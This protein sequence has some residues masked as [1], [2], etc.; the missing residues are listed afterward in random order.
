MGRP[1]YSIC[2]TNYNTVDVIER[3]LESIINRINFSDC[4][5]I[6]VDSK[7]TDGSLEILRRYE[8]KYPQFKVIVKKCLRG[9]GWQTAFENSKGEFIIIVACD[10]IYNDLWTKIIKY[11]MRNNLDFALSMWFCQIYPRG[12]LIKVGGWNNLQYLEDADLWARIA[13]YKRYYTY[14]VVCGENLKRE[15]AKNIIERFYR[16]Y[17]RIHDKL[18]VTRNIPIKYYLLGYWKAICRKWI[19]IHRVTRIIF[20]FSCL[21]PAVIVKSLRRSLHKYGDIATLREYN[22]VVDF[23]FTDKNKLVTGES[24]DTVESVKK[25]YEEGD[26][27]YL[28]GFYD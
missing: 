10:T 8:K 1:Q 26:L 28:P 11:Y 6:V 17:K 23:G 16:I 2:M 15:P 18:L 25:A 9:T 12:L 20:Y 4:E 7:S 5:I 13:K 14:P 19:G 22:I 24:Y 3:S 27:N 21:I